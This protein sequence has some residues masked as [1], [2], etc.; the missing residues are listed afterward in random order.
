LRAQSP[1]E[2]QTDFSRESPFSVAVL[3]LRRFKH[4]FQDDDENAGAD[5]GI[6]P[7]IF[8]S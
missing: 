4:R 6:L 1:T 2:L 5:D 8:F 7:R 3:F